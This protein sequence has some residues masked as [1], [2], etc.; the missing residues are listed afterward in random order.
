MPA[1]IVIP[2]DGIPHHLNH[3]GR[4]IR[5]TCR[6]YFR[7]LGNVCLWAYIVYMHNTIKIV[8]NGI[9]V[10]G[11][12]LQKAHFS[13]GNYTEKS[14]IPMESITIYGK[15]Y[16]DFSSEIR[17]AFEVTNSTDMMT[18]YFENDRIVV[19]PDHPYYA[20]VLAAYQAQE[21]HREK[22]CK[23]RGL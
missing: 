2:G 20:Q 17:L 13:K 10:N 18:D 6:G 22:I 1:V 9:K 21:V 15:N 14:G 3:R 5:V 23:R 16:R 4:P 7:Y 19:R 12:E 11:G 8:W